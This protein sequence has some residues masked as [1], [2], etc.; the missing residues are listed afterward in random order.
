MKKV[1]DTIGR[2]FDR[3]NEDHIG[4]YTAQCAYFTFLS[5]IPFI[6]LLLSLIKYMN[7]ERE[8]LV[9]I[10]EAVLPAITKNSVLDI[11]QEVYSK[12]FEAVSISAIFLLWSAANSFYSLSLGLSSIYKG[13]EKENRILLRIKGVIG[14]IIA[15]F[16]VIM[17]LILMVFGNRINS[18]IEENFENFSG[19]TTFILSIRNIIV[20]GGLFTMFVIMYRFVPNKKGNR[21]KKQIPGAIFASIRLVCTFI[22]FLNLCRCVYKFFCYI[23]KFSYNNFNHDVALCNNLCNFIWCRD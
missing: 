13:E 14:T 22:F 19:I 3:L 7:I 11:I 1:M 4:E 5:F 23:W 6:I 8:T 21:V 10:L 20:I 15:I 2:F 16:S 9:Y 12:S 18:I 17:V